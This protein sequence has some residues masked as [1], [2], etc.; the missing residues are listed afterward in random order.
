MKG[1][2]MSEQG[3]TLKKRLFFGI[4]DF[5]GGGAFQLINL[6]Y[7]IFLTDTVGLSMAY[8][9]PIF[10]IGKLWD[11][12]TDPLMG[13]ISD[14]TNSRYGRRRLY[15]V[16]GSFSVLI[17]MILLWFPFGFET[18]I[19]KF[20]AATITFMLF[21]TAY[22]IV[23]VPYV[24][25]GAELAKTYN[26]R[27]KL[28]FTRLMFSL[29]GAL[30]SSVLP[31][32]IINAFPEQKN[33]YL[34]MGI[35]FAFIYAGCVFMV[36]FAKADEEV[37]VKKRKKINFIEQY[38]RIISIKSFRY[39]ILMFIFANL[40]SDIITIMV[41]YYATY[42]LLRAKLTS[43]IV[44]VAFI[45]AIL[46]TPVW[47]I[48]AQR[49]DKKFAYIMGVVIRVLIG[50]MIFFLPSSA[51]PLLLYVLIFFLNIGISS[52]IFIPHAMFADISDVGEFVTKEKIEGQLSGIVTFTRK[53]SAG[54]GI[55]LVTSLLSV[56]GYIE[57]IGN[58]VVV[59]SEQVLLTMRLLLSIVPTL[60]VVI[61]G[62]YCIKNP[63]TKK[64]HRILSSYLDDPNSI[65]NEE[66]RD[67][68]DH[69][70]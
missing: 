37:V 60:L 7:A 15:F 31:L 43:A 6:V 57:P 13:Y 35:L 28:N 50:P 32:S 33:G 3:L 67:L 52:T 70:V 54:I 1:Y 42:F 24:A 20:M 47:S 39:Y 18:Q 4:G 16:I 21:N 53:L 2:N 26:D 41:A 62:Y 44:A 25:H 66:L 10:L 46:F 69:L 29:L 65:N 56:V 34:A 58:E 17:S 23:M 51:S 59:Q 27:T 8:V 64:R 12:I 36:F 40:G 68:H 48:V 5:Y 22:T 49:K 55:F 11:A 9:G 61:G 63:V 14:N 38:K 45:T 19:A 30:I